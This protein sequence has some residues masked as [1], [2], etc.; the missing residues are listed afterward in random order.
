[1]IVGGLTAIGAAIRLA[2]P[3]R[4][5]F[6][7]EL[8]TYWI[9]A[10]PSATGVLSLVGHAYPGGSTAEISPPLYF[11]LAWLTT[12]LGHAPE[13]VR[14]PSL[15][16]GIG[17]VPLVYLVGK[18]TVGRSAGLVAAGLSAFSPF[19]IYYSGEARGYALMVFLLLASTLAMLLALDTGRRRYWALYAVASGLAMLTHYTAVFLLV[20][21]LMWLLWTHRQAWRA[22]L[23]ANLGAVILFSPW[24]P[25][26]IRQFR[27]PTLNI[28]NSLSPFN[29]HSARVSL[30]HWVIG[31]PYDEVTLRQ[32]PGLPAVILLLGALVLSLAAAAWQSRGRTALPA[33]RGEQ[34]WT[35]SRRGLW[36]AHRRLGL[37]A[38]LALS[39]PVG[40]ALESAVGTHTF[41][42]RNL[43]G[44]T[45]G[46]LLALAAILVAPRRP[47][48]YATVGLA[49]AAFVWGAVKMVEPQYQR[50]DTGAA[51]RYVERHIRPG[52]VVIDETVLRSPGPL[53]PLDTVL[54]RGI[55]VF[56]AGGPA[57]R[58]HPFDRLPGVPLPI[59]MRTA[60]ARFPHARVFVVGDTFPITPADVAK[61]LPSHGYLSDHE[62]HRLL[63][64]LIHKVWAIPPSYHQIASRFYAGVPGVEV[65][66]FGPA[67][68]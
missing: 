38:I 49:M 19:L 6:A 42:G 68:G 8:S 7:D 45:T 32:V 64:A 63:L 41:G 66:V 9:S 55:P 60:L 53:S 39:V 11:L 48:R 54:R 33:D 58:D 12:Q 20:G 59:A 23:V 26:A 43:A 15:L 56:R 67:N 44:S 22:A 51:A 46:V 35:L 21:Q 27:S 25:A 40:E 50:P 31:Y 57:E 1:L 18:R 24:I 29:F 17:T 14:L 13:L 34:A 3:D 65:N 5:L 10:R 37:V 30:F 16:A 52:D 47:I 61:A 2:H 36:V 62:R 4:A 28:L